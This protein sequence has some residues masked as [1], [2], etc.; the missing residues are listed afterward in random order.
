MKSF[1][2]EKYPLIGDLPTREQRLV[3]VRSS[4]IPAG[5]QTG[6]NSRPSSKI[7][8]IPNPKIFQK[9]IIQIHPP[10]K[11]IKPTNLILSTCI[12]LVNYY[13]TNKK[14]CVTGSTADCAMLHLQVYYQLR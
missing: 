13:S 4:K 9:I 3:G 11:T 14:T 8:E 6:T 12:A 2:R 7:N 5:T 10:R 1:E